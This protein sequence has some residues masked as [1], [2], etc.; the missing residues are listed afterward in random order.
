MYGIY[1][2]VPF[3][4]KRCPYCHFV[5]VEGDADARF[6]DAV[7]RHMEAHAGA[8]MTSLYFGGGTPSKL[9]PGAVA[10][11]IETA[12]RLFKADGPME[13][14]LEANPEDAARLRAFRDAGVN[15]LSLGVQ[16]LSDAA[17]RFLGRGHDAAQ[18]RAAYPAGFANVSVDLIFGVPGQD[19]DADLRE[20]IA[21]DPQHVSL[22]GLTVEPGTELERAVKRGRTLPD[23]E[24]QKRDYELAMDL[25]GAAGYRHYEISNFARPGFESVHNSGY[26]DGR[27]YLG[28][29]PGAHSYVPH[30][31]W[32]NVSNVERYLAG[33][34]EPL[35]A[36]DL[37]RDQRMLEAV[38]LGLRRDVGVDV[39][40]F[41]RAFA[42]DFR[43]HYAAALAKSDGALEWAGGRLR[44][45]RRGRLLADAVIAE[46]A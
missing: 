45:T 19:F 13:I 46:F 11:L 18:A 24:A 41:E 30:R 7:R 26:W 17:L 36:E 23:D 10:T 1:V 6:V 12:R 16:S 39:A 37:S 42:V 43:S 28:F 31:R 2:H 33:A 3:C 20:I 4:T 5:L 32:A 34:L 8:P 29:G 25:L 35:M 27:P 38:F 40:A 9:A 15:R 21:W 14:T 44:L 22:Y